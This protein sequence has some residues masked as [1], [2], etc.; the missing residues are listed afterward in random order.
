MMDINTRVHLVA[1]YAINIITVTEH[2]Q[3]IDHLIEAGGLKILTEFLHSMV[4]VTVKHTLFGLSNIGAGCPAHAEAVLRD[5]ALM[6]RI[7]TLLGHRSSVIKNEAAWAL[8]QALNTASYQERRDFHCKYR[9]EYMK[10]LVAS[11]INFREMNVDLILAF[12]NTLN[13][14]LDLDLTDN[15]YN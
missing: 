9:R 2:T 6:Y 10:K 12:V 8:I 11:L 15:V 1:H 13:N 5:E 7:L 14:L 4:E 3:I